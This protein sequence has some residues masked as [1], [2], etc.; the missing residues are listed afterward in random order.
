MDFG[1]FLPVQ[2]ISLRRGT[3][4]PFGVARVAW[5]RGKGVKSALGSLR[6]ELDLDCGSGC[7]S[8]L[9]ISLSDKMVATVY[10]VLE[11]PPSM[12]MISPVTK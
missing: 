2:I 8:H 6:E 12:M 5:Q 4:S 7:P 9:R 11:N 3:K 10:V 1:Q